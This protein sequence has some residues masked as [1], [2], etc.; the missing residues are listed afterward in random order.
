MR[1]LTDH[2]VRSEMCWPVLSQKMS[3]WDL[4][5][6]ENG[7]FE[8]RVCESQRK[9]ADFRRDIGLSR[10]SDLGARFGCPIHFPSQIWDFEG[11]IEM[12]LVICKIWLNSAL[13]FREKSISLTSFSPKCEVRFDKVEKAGV[14]SIQQIEIMQIAG[15]IY[16]RKRAPKS[17]PREAL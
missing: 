8:C 7:P 3:L 12:V 10:N 13:W 1:W 6:T 17:F 14:C 2:A 11:E 15:V 4:D 9:M 5:A 16:I